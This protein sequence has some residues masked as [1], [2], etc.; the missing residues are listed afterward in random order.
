VAFKLC[1][2]LGMTLELC[3]LICIPLGMTL[4]VCELPLLHSMV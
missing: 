1:I 4:E 2:P 3:K